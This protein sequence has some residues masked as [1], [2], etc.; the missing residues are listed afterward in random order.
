MSSNQTAEEVRQQ[1]LELLGEELGC[2]YHALWNETAWLYMNWG[3]Y[4]EI[5]GTKPSRVELVNQVAGQFF[6][7]VQDS[8]LEG[9]L[10]HIARLTDPPKSVGK[11]N[12]TIL[13]LP[14]LI[15]E[16]DVR[17]NVALLIEDAVGKADF[18]RDWRNR[19]LAHKDLRLALESGA[20][21]LKPASRA[22]VKEALASISDVLDAVSSHYMNSTTSFEGVGA[23]NGALSLLYTL[24][25]GLQAEKAREERLRMG[26]SRVDDYKARDL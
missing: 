8:L 23:R 2:L 6:R 7:L 25:D 11:D 1:H 14:E 20:E 17:Q 13:R 3:E 22:K 15:D 5:F 24:D 4:V 18:C 19:R 10:L 12:L 26:G 16:E 21:P 9:T